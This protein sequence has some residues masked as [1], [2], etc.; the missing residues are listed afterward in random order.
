[1]RSNLPERSRGG[2]SP[3]PKRAYLRLDDPALTASTLMRRRW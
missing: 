1:M 3:A 2:I